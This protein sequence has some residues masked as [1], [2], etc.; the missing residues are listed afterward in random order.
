MSGLYGYK[1][2][3]EKSDIAIQQ[4]PWEVTTS[5]GSGTSNGPSAILQASPQLDLFSYDRE[6]LFKN[7]TPHLI[8]AEAEIAKLKES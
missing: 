1:T 2:D 8:K 7:N 5:Y 3:L 6:Q 4:I